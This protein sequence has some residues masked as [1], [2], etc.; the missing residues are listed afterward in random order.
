MQRSKQSPRGQARSD[1]KNTEGQ[2]KT[3]LQLD[4]HKGI[5]SED[6]DAKKQ[7]RQMLQKA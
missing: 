5:I 3:C 2:K 7:M 6:M 4:W 1:V